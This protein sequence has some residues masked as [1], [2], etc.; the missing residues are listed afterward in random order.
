MLPVTF[1]EVSEFA[2]TMKLL[3]SG[4]VVC[5][6]LQEPTTAGSKIGIAGPVENGRLRF[7][8]AELVCAGTIALT[9]V[10]VVGTEVVGVEPDAGRLRSG[11]AGPPIPC[12][13][14]LIEKE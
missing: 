5:W 8:I 4:V 12:G 6:R 1:W 10:S 7:V 9:S 11:L 13:S 3:V 2:P 14:S